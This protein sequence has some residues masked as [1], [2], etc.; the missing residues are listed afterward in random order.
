MTSAGSPG[1]QMPLAVSNACPLQE[2]TH[3]GSAASSRVRISAKNADRNLLFGFV[4]DSARQGGSY[5]YRLNYLFRYPFSAAS[6]RVTLLCENQS[7]Q[8]GF[9][10][11]M[12][13]TALIS[14][15]WDADATVHERSPPKCRL[16]RGERWTMPA[17]AYSCPHLSIPRTSRH[18]DSR[19]SDS[20]QTT[21]S[22]SLLLFNPPSPL[23]PIPQF[24]KPCTNVTECVDERQRTGTKNEST[25]AQRSRPRHKSC[26][27]VGV[28][29]ST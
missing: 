21:G 16:L 17:I 3:E 7:G 19:S 15:D 2:C 14:F 12:P 26:S 8:S 11:I 23:L 18:Q 4:A 5:P 20:V 13:S 10:R 27:R 24:L 6:M 25:A 29:T 28:N 22:M 1:V 9:S